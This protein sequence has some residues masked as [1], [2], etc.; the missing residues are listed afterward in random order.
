MKRLKFVRSRE[1]KH[2]L[3]YGFYR[4]FFV[5][6]RSRFTQKFKVA[7]LFPKNRLPRNN[8]DYLAAFA[9]LYFFY[10]RP[11]VVVFVYYYFCHLSD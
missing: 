4:N 8:Q 2:I 1:R 10:Y 6:F 5:Q 11:R 9:I 7:D 3:I